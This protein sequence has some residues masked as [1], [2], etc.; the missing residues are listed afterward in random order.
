MSASTATDARHARLGTNA[1]HATA[2][3]AEAVARATAALLDGDRE[4]AEI[5]AARH[6]VIE[7]DCRAMQD[8][9]DGDDVAVA[10]VASRIGAELAAASALARDIAGSVPRVPAA[11]LPPR[12]RGLLG[13]IGAETRHLVLGLPVCEPSTAVVDDLHRRLLAELF[14]GTVPVATAVELTVVGRR[15]ER[16]AAHAI[17]VAADVRTVTRTGR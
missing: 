2:E 16:L 15:Y 3:V 4:L 12:V 8:P 13:R 5:V 6:R 11:S 9:V 10:V 17:A 7:L 14:A 1:L